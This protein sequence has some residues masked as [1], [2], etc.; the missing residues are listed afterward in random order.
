MF[1]MEKIKTEKQDTELFFLFISESQN[2][3]LKRHIG[4]NQ[5]SIKIKAYKQLICK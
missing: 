1:L 5:I 4:M 3:N 2:S